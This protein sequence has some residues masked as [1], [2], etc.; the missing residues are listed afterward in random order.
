M[1][2]ALP[3]M[4]G[5]KHVAGHAAFIFWAI[6]LAAHLIPGF[7]NIPVLEEV[8]SGPDS[9]PY[10]L[11]LNFD[12]PLLLFALILAWPQVMGGA[13]RI[14]PALLGSAVL[15]AAVLLPLAAAAHAIKW[16]P[17]L[18]TWLL[19]F[20]LANLLQTC[21][22][23]EAFFRGYLQRLLIENLGPVR[24]IGLA[25]LLFG[26]AHFPGGLALIAF[27]SLLGLACGLAMHASNRLSPAIW[28]H[29]GF[30]LAHLLLFTYPAAA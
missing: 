12:K 13:A 26:L 21:L 14:R 23:E 5:W 15:L 28:L 29:F 11:Y 30:N 27:A 16:E 20:V 6:A 9:T 18:P 10:T 8:Q 24:G 3:R 4:T 2:W 7:H 17:A 25:S 1:A 22:V 19:L